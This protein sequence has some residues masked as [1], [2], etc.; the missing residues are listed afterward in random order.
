[1]GKTEQKDLDVIL[2]I[3]NTL[4]ADGGGTIDV[5]DIEHQHRATASYQP[6]AK[7]DM[8]HDL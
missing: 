1:M 8:Y 5:A 6:P 3:F 2:G 7:P 4:D